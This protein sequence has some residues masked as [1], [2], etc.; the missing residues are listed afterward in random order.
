VKAVNRQVVRP[1][2]LGGQKNLEEV[3]FVLRF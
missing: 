2:K 3:T 1:I